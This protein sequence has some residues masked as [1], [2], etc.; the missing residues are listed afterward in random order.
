M[1]RTEPAWAGRTL[2]VTGG[3]SGIGAAVCLRA[4]ARGAAVVV[5]DLDAKAAARTATACGSGAVHAHVDVTDSQAMSA[6]VRQ[7]CAESGGAVWGL[8][9]AAGI[10]S[11][12]PIGTI[13]PVEAR[14][15]LDVNV[16]GVINAI[17]AVLPLLARGS[18]V[19]NI[20]S[21]AA[22]SG[23]GFFGASTYA[24]SKAAV[25]GLTRGVARELAA[26]GVRVNCVAPGPVDTPMLESLAP[27]DRTRIAEAALLRRLSTA[28]DIAAAICFLLSD[29]AGS[30][31]GETVNVNGGACFA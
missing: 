23:G 4:A 20:S 10:V 22:H 26:I 2:V 16:L 11:A 19:V 27:G 18:G 13:A 31:T 3:G 24:A 12:Q 17:Q 25:I 5:L 6:S 1:T 29:E 8:V 30:I 9:T 28:Q 15:V 14:R 21:V 7:A